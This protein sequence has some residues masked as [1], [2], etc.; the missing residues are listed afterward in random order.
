MWRS[1]P[2]RGLDLSR[3]RRDLGTR[4]RPHQPVDDDTVA[5]FEAGADD[6]EAILGHRAR[7]HDLWLDGAALLHG[8]H[9]LARLIGNDGAVGDQD[10]DMLLRGGNANA[11]ELPGSDEI[12]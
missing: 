2:S 3:L 4:P 12:T 9:Q 7:T 8:H 5:R 1:L 10:R 6:A 11:P